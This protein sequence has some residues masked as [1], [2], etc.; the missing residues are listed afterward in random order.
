M[1]IHT[2]EDLLIF[3]QW[4]KWAYPIVVDVGDGVRVDP[5][6]LYVHGVPV[7]MEVDTNVVVLVISL[8]QQQ[9]LFPAAQLQPASIALHMYTAQQEKRGTYLSMLCMRPPEGL[10]T[11]HCEGPTFAWTGLTW[12]A[13]HGVVFSWKSFCRSTGKCS[14]RSLVRSVKA[15][16]TVKENCQSVFLTLYCPFCNQGCH[17]AAG[18]LENV[19]FS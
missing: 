17:K 1:V 7:S 18:I 13:R 10:L 2:S 16:L 15:T 8:K 11:G 9:E 5:W 4:S 19:E 6:C 12:H 3:C 14:G